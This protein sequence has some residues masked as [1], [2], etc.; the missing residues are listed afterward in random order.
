MLN[1]RCIEIQIFGKVGI[2]G[3]LDLKMLKVPMT[4]SHQTLQNSAGNSSLQH[5]NA[6]KIK[7]EHTDCNNICDIEMT[8]S[9]RH[10]VQY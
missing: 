9:C 10:E 5:I 2:L 1:L 4:N 6:T 3:L 7:H 8:W